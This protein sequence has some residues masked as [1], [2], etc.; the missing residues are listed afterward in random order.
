LT[1]AGTGEH[2]AATSRPPMNREARKKREAIQS[3]ERFP[4]C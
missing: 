3:E 1:L 4:I 2:A